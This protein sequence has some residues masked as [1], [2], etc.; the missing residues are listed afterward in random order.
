MST[1]SALA[2]STATTAATKPD[3]A[4]L[5]EDEEDHER[6]ADKVHHTVDRT[7]VAQPPHDG[8]TGS[9]EDVHRPADEPAERV[10]AAVVLGAVCQR[11]EVL[12]TLVEELPPHG[13]E[14]VPD[15]ADGAPQH[16]A[17]LVRAVADRVRDRQ[18]HHDDSHG[19]GELDE[20]ENC[21][22]DELEHW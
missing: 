5:G 20:E 7:T 8:L 14:V 11:A 18:Q 22:T 13:P 9:D 21:L 12:G 10:E 1:T 17:G 15:G 16:V 4:E 3:V 19:H 2:V 6:H